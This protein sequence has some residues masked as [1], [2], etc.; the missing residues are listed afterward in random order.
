MNG[1]FSS[2]HIQWVNLDEQDDLFFIPML[3]KPVATLSPIQA[4]DLL[5]FHPKYQAWISHLIVIYW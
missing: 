5:Y 2:P 3:G 1:A 4:E